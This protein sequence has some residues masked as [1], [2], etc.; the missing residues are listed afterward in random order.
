MLHSTSWLEGQDEAAFHPSVLAGSKAAALPGA[1]G[2]WETPRRL[3]AEQ[4]GVIPG[5]RVGRA[6]H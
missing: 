4:L 1:R 3:Q 6:G 5:N 2:E